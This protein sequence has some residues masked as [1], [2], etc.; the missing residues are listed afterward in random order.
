MAVITHVVGNGAVTVKIPVPASNVTVQAPDL[1]VTR[2]V[3]EPPVSLRLIGNPAVA[4]SEI[5][6]GS[7]LSGSCVAPNESETEVV[8]K[9]PKTPEPDLMTV[10]LQTPTRIPVTVDVSVV[11]V[12]RAHDGL[13]VAELFAI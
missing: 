8:D 3:P 7:S 13:L 12:L 1:N 11:D 9:A 10:T 4:V 2:P 6:T 5:E